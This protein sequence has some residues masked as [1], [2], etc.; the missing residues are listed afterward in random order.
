MFAQESIL[1]KISF[2]SFCNSGIERIVIPKGV[3]EIPEGAF[4]ECTRL[5]EVAFEEESRLKT[6]GARAFNGC[7]NLANVILP[8][9]LETIGYNAFYYCESL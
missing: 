1:E 2:R 6:I 8:E 5:K 7:R 3:A 4:Y 9:G